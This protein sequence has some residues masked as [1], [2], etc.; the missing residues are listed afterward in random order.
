V[1][2]TQGV[3]TQTDG[4]FSVDVSQVTLPC[5]ARVEYTDSA[6][7]APQRL[8]SLV[9]D[10]G[11]IN[12]TPVTDLVVARLSSSGVAADAYDRFNADDVKGYS[13][14]R[15]RTAT[16][17]VRTQLKSLGVDTSHLPDDVIGAPLVAASGSGPGDRH[18]GVLDDLRD[19]LHEHHKSLD[20]VEREMREGHETRGPSTST[21]LA[22]DAAAGKAAYEANCQACHGARVADAV[23]A[24]KTLKAIRENEGGM[25]RLGSTVDPAMAD[26]IATYLANGVG[27]GTATVLKAQSIAFGSPGN[28]TIGTATPPLVATAT[29]GLAVTI[30]SSTPAV[31]TVSNGSL[32]LVAPGTCSMSA[33]QGGNATYSAAATVTH[34]FTVAARTGVVLLN[35]SISFA[36]PGAQVVG[37]PAAL[38]ASAD[39]GL[40]V[41]FASTTPA[42]CTVSGGTLTPVAAGNC[43]VTA[44]QGGDSVY[45][46]A[47]TVTRTVT[48]TGPAA[49]AS[50]ANGKLLYAT[51]C[52]GC[53]GPA[54]SNGF[55]VLAGANSPATIRAAINR[56]RGGM[57]SLS[58][59]GDPELADIAAYLATPGI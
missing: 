44:N 1:G 59:I 22:G 2:V 37:T 7:S 14:D 10:E 21:G 24:A 29:S 25:G 55:N 48:V 18:D 46:A 19:K 20:D 30:A 12:I 26:D 6:A 34:S 13:G 38:S 43:T 32:T 40:A 45:A 54:A 36:S 41:S 17:M 39:S 50:A 11:H 27:G 5:V 15:V 9:R 49:V 53:H 28:Q 31:C 35:Q 47:A 8:H 3:S 51:S 33:S 52:G 57:G 23:N 58:S 56:N 16:E 42:V 4:S